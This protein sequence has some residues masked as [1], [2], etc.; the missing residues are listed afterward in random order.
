MTAMRSAPAY[1]FDA[2]LE[3][4]DAYLVETD[5]ASNVDS[6][7]K[8]VTVGDAIF[9][10]MGVVDVSVIEIAS[11]DELYRILIQGSTTLAFTAGT[12]QNLAVLELGA[13]EVRLG[14]AVDSLVGRYFLPF[15]NYQAGITYPYIR[16]YTDVNGT[17]A[18]GGG[19]NH[20]VWV[21]KTR[22]A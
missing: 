2:E 9:S 18:G 16:A 19:I 1:T 8:V 12:I 13:T 20:K 7:A 21:G 15:V 22:A 6:A 17:I 11:N 4:K 14:A 10:G 3:L 5:A